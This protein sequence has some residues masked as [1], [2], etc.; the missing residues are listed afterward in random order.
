MSY[1]KIIWQNIIKEYLV[2][3]R[4]PIGL[5]LNLLLPLLIL[6]VF[7]ISFPGEFLKIT[8]APILILEDDTNHVLIKELEKKIISEDFDIFVAKGDEEFLEQEVKSEDYLLG[9]YPHFDNQTVK[10]LILID[11]SNPLAMETALTR[12]LPRLDTSNVLIEEKKIYGERLGF[13]DYL[14]PG[15]IALGI[16]FFTLNLAAAGVA[17]ERVLGS[18]ERVLSSPSPL[19][20]F[21]AAKYISYI[22]LSLVAG[23]LLLAGGTL[24]FNIPIAGDI[25]LVALLGVFTAMPFIGIAL[26]A[27]VIG[28]SEFEALAIAEIISV[29][30]IFI[31]G[32]FF[33]IQCMPSYVQ[34]IANA[35]PL[36]YSTNALRDVIIRGLGF[37]DVMYALSALAVYT[38]AFFVLTIFIFRKRR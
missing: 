17:K 7:G 29:P 4:R 20:L 14:L 31:C 30:L 33:P 10:T 38:L 25:W 2:L 32:V 16:M 5:T 27:S 8:Y 18:L 36:A 12:L 34:G 9:I 24:L 3:F 28:K 21:L 23:M 22:F 19:W 15:I 13:V 35:L 11:N 6:L 1:L 37:H 26:I